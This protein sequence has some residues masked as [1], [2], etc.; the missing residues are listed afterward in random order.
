[1]TWPGH[2]TSY[3]RHQAT[4]IYFSRAMRFYFQHLIFILL[5]SD[6]QLSFATL[7]DYFAPARRQHFII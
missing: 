4:I 6:A 7:G 3:G 2:I 5:R 1:M